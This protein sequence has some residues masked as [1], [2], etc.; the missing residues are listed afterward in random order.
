MKAELR[1]EHDWLHKLV[2]EWT[3]EFEAPGTDAQPPTVLKGTESVRS[4]QHAWVVGHGRGPMPDGSD[5]E[6]MIT[7]G[8]D[9]DRERF[10]GTWVGTM[11]N[12]MWIYD[13]ELDSSGRVLTLS[14]E[15]PSM[16]GQKHILRYQDVIEFVTD[17]HRTL[18][19]RVQNADG[20][21]HD[22]MVVNYRRR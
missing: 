21:W 12:H 9:P 20:Q 18:T 3:T 22:M 11:M 1:K 10:V 7:L 13:G 2:G 8:F 6:S 17:D 15:G 19:G 5:S 16:D 4:M 14:S